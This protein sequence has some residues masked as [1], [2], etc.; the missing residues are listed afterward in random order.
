MEKIN[1]LDFKSITNL[2]KIFKVKWY[3]SDIEKNKLREFVTRNNY[4]GFIHAFGHLFLWFLTGFRVTRGPV[5]PTTREKPF[6][7]R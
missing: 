3:R 4:K 2:K 1:E 6:W 5:I 7:H